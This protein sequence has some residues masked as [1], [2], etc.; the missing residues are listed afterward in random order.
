VFSNSDNVL[1]VAPNGSSLESSRSKYQP[2]VKSLHAVEHPNLSS[3][4]GKKESFDGVISISGTSH[5]NEQFTELSSLLKSGGTLLLNEP[6]LKSSSSSQLRDERALFLALTVAGFI[7]V[8]I[9]SQPIEQSGLIFDDIVIFEVSAKKPNFKVGSSQSLPKRSNTSKSNGTSSTQNKSSVWTLPSDDIDDAELADED[10]LL[11]DLDKAKPVQKPDDCEVG[12]DGKKRACK[13][14]VCG[15]KEEEEG[16]KPVEAPK[17][18]CGNC[19]LGD[20][21]RCSSCPYLG[22]PSFKPG[23]KVE[24]QLDAIDV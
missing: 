22:M 8:K 9:K 23:E 20:A 16:L 24:L 2:Q 3:L 6:G 11:D 7:D 5:K 19:Y 17:S 10:D 18:S 14:C 12:K 4:T 13:N 21:F 1:L 15:R